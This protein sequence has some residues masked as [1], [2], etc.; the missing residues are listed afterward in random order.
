MRVL[1]TAA[2]RHGTT[3]EIAWV[4]AGVLRTFNLTVDVMAPDEVANIDAY[5]AVILG[6]AV[7]AGQWLEPAKGFVVR[8][9]QE[10]ADRPLFL[11]SSGPLGD[12]PKPATE[13]EDAR[14]IEASTGA[15]DQRVF[16]GRLMQS[17]LSLPE[18][19]VVRAEHAPYGDFRPWDDIA[20]WATEIARYLRAES[21]EAAHPGSGG[22]LGADWPGER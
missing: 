15:M 9:Q 1:I 20:D 4:I 12:P 21:E 11:F 13:P 22:K 17:Q 10:L 7:Y 5:D 2:S 6:S 16:A 14:A 19:L 8:H 18:R 3:A